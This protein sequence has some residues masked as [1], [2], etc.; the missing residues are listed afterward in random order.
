MQLIYNFIRVHYFLQLLKYIE[1]MVLYA[2]HGVDSNVVSSNR[3]VLLHG[4]PGTG[5][6]NSLKF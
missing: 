2:D 5:T 3:L 1:A 4:P 6:E